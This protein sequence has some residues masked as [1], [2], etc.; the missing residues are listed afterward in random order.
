[1]PN[2]KARQMP[3]TMVAISGVS[4]SM[5]RCRLPHDWVE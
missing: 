2:T 5:R 3:A 1:V 4:C